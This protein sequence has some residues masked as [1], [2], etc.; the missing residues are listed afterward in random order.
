MYQQVQVVM[1]LVRSVSTSSGS[2]IVTNCKRIFDVTSSSNVMIIMAKIIFGNLQQTMNFKLK[3]N[4]I[5]P[6]DGN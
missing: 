3:S 1:E 5:K 4:R 2:E 6:I